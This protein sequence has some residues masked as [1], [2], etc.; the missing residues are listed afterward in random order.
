MDS[1]SYTALRMHLASV[2]DKVNQDHQPIMITRQNNQLAVIMS[3]EKF[4][5]YETAGTSGSDSKDAET[6]TPVIFKTLT[7]KTT[8]LSIIKRSHFDN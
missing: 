5:S 4:Q 8:K 6:L 7:E 1:I 3:L 2:L